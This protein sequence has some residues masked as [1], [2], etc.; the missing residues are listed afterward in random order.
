VKH[1]A[2]ITTL[3]LLLLSLALFSFVAKADTMS[4]VGVNGS[5]TPNGAEY[6]G[7]YTISVD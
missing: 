3:P 1:L 4:F 6:T 5:E 7:P 2:K